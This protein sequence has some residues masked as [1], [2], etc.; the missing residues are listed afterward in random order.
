MLVHTDDV[1][2]TE[3]HFG[4]VRALRRMLGAAAGARQ[5]GLSQ[6]RIA[7]GDVCAPQH[8]HADEEELFFVVSGAGHVLHGRSAHPVAAGDVFAFPAA[9]KPH[10]VLGG[11]IEVLA[12][13]SGATSGLTWVTRSNTMWARPRWLPLDGDQPFAAEA[14]LGPL[15]LAD[16]TLV[17]ERPEWIVALADVPGRETRRGATDVVRADLGRAV[18]TRLSG[19]K[20]VAIAPNAESHPPHCH[21][22]EEELF[23]VLDGTG[24]LLLGDETLPVRRGHVLARPAGTG[25]AHSW[26]AGAQGLTLL[27]YGQRKPD[28]ICFYP[29]S[30]KIAIRGLRATFRVQQADYWDGEE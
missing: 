26:R 12:F 15:R 1:E 14:A 22:A 28:D 11:P 5:A 2:E 18:G 21:S 10:T 8:V 6:W 13:G 17:D 20:H 23:V 27:A 16:Y 4:H 30:G 25:V 19:L 24:D 9:G 29:R 3:R 7:D